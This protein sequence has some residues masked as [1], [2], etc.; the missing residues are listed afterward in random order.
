MVR[1]QAKTFRMARNQSSNRKSNLG[2][3][4]EVEAIIG[5]CTIT[6]VHGTKSIETDITK[7]VI[8]ETQ[9]SS[10]GSGKTDDNK[11]VKISLFLSC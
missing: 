3:E 1:H 5:R 10:K 4:D 6:E 8:L 7:D 11:N 2:V 9:T